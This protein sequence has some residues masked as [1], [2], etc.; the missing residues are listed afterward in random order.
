M[1]DSGW[2][3]DTN[4]A[5]TTTRQSTPVSTLAKASSVVDT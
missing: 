4:S 2:L 5:L 1:D 3:S